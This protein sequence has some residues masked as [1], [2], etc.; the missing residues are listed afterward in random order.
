M[1]IPLYGAVL[2]LSAFLLFW[3]QPL[4]TKM[5]LPLLGGSPSVWNTALMFFQLTLLAGYGY[6]HL[7]NRFLAPRHQAWLHGAVAAASLAFLPIGLAAGTQPAGHWPALWLIGLLAASLGLPFFTLAATAPLLQSWFSRTGHRHGADP[8][9]LYAAS[10]A[11]SLLALFAF[12]LL[13]EP[14]LTLGEQ[15]RS[16]AWLYAGLL[17]LVVACAVPA[18]HASRLQ[19]TDRT[20][21]RPTW[22]LSLIHI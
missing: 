2:F 9:F 1:L 5:A 17:A 4:F 7:L 14:R 10:N 20:D 6:A 19:Q 3:V 11:G 13:L 21:T 8:Y 22:R 16:W 15:S 18:R 12:P